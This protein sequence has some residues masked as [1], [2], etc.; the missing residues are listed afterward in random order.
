MLEQILSRENMLQAMRRVVENN[1][2]AGI[3]GILA[4]DLPDLIKSVWLSV[5]TAIL[6]GSYWPQPVR[7]VMIPKANGGERMLGIPTVLDRM[8][9][10]AISQVLTEEY[11]PTFSE[12]SYGFRPGRDAHQATEQAQKYLNEGYTT[13]VELDLE[14]FFDRVN[15]DRLMYKLSLR[16]EDKRLLLLIRR[17]LTAG[18]MR[19]G[20]FRK[21]DEGT[22]Q[23]SPLSPLLSNIVLDELDKELE[24]RGHRFVRYA[25]DC[26]IYLKSRRSGDRTNESITRYIEKVLRLKVNREKTHVNRPSKTSLLGFSF[27]KDQKGWQIRIHPKSIARIKAKIRE[28]TKRRYTISLEDRLT[29]LKQVIRGWVNYFKLAKA[30]KIMNGLDEYS[31][32]RLRSCVWAL[33]KRVRTRMRG[34]QQLGVPFGRAYEY[35]NTRKGPTRISRSPI[36]HTTLTN[37]K[38]ADFGYISFTSC[39][40]KGTDT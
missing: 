1:G 3:D 6:E 25:D 35:A 27:Y 21:R 37:Q 14:K 28:L 38:L 8:I 20:L 34:L 17:Y 40:T 29:R 39:Y 12:N 2:A 4:E 7:E 24:R 16:I 11:D 23:G 5:R 22:P 30:K 18:I 26:S 33:W 31:R 15:H 32:A 19:D 36:L 9:Q 10:Q 13:V